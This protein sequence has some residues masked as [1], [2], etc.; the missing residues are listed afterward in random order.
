MAFRCAKCGGDRISRDARRPRENDS[1][2]ASPAASWRSAAM[3]STCSSLREHDIPPIDMVVVNLYQFE[4]YAAQGRM[5]RREE[6]IENIDIGGP[7]MIR[8]AAKNFQD[9]AV[10][11]SPDRVRADHRASCRQR[12]EHSRRRHTGASRRRRSRT[13]RPTIAPSAARL[14]RINGQGDHRTRRRLLPDVLRYHAPRAAVA[15]ATAKI[16]IS[17]RRSIQLGTGGIAGAKQLHGKELSYNNLVDLDAAWQ[18]IQEFERPAAAIIKHTN[19]CGCAEQA[20]LAEAT[21]RRSKPIRFRP[22]AACWRSIAKWMTR[23][24]ARSRKTFRRSDRGARL[25]AGGARRP[26]G[27]EESASRRS[28]RQSRAGSWW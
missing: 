13:P 8:A 24:R 28:R 7:T 4:K 18:L 6:L 19:P 23:P 5:S 10:V 21:G 16:R 3:P 22:S 27:K 15:C 1:S 25:F 17:K 14:A 9:V 26:Y 12:A 2:R 20:T 11:V